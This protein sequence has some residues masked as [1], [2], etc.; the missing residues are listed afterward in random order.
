[1]KVVFILPGYPCKPSGGFRVVYEY[2]NQLVDRGHKIVIIHLARLPGEGNSSLLK[3]GYRLLMRNATY[4]RNVFCERKIGWQFVDPRIQMIY[5]IDLAPHHIP[6]ADVIFATSWQTAEIILKCLVCKGKKFYLIQHYE[7]WSGPKERVEATWRAPFYKVV[8]ARWLYEKGLDLG[9]LEEEMIH[10]PNGI[11]HE[12]FKIVKPIDQRP[13]T[14]A[15][16]YSHLDWKGATDGIKAL[17]LAKNKLPQLQAILFGSRRRPLSLPHWIRYFQNPPQAVIRDQIYNASSIYLCPSW[18]EGWALPSAE[19]MACGCA[20]ISTDNGGIRDYAV[21]EETAL[22]SPPKTPEALARN[23]IRLVENDAL[24]IMLAQA[25]H[26]NIQRFT[27]KQSADF[28]ERFLMEKIKTHPPTA[29]D[30]NR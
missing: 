12:F 24:R 15:M 23:I 26:Q 13:P 5:V 21:H 19:A 10:I 11:N 17:E 29:L 8:I 4:L 9:I 3:N 16:M 20:V 27:W 7:V 14:V 22:I 6:E 25:G 2:S 18:T 28:L 1:M 30:H